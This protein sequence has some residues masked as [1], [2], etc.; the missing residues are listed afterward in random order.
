MSKKQKNKNKKDKNHEKIKIYV[1][2]NTTVGKTSYIF[3]LTQNFFHE[4]YVATFGIDYHTE[5]MKLSNGIE[6]SVN[7]YDTAG[8][9]RYHSIALNFIRSCDGIILMYD[10]TDEKSF[11]SI[12]KW[13]EDINDN[14]N[15]NYPII[16]L[17]NKSDLEGE[18]MISKEAGEELAKKYDISF[19]ETSNKDGKNVNEAWLDL[20]NKIINIKEKNSLLNEFVIVENKSFTLEEM[21]EINEIEENSSHR[22]RRLGSRNKKCLNL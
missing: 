19:F 20:S 8:Q 13:M 17:G 18:R 9:E 5:I 16:L 10:I 4:N 15:P 2:G 14:M 22:G 11:N 12:P 1:L 21:N 7:F 6:Y 3:K